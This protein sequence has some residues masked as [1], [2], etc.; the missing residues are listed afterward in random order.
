MSIIT[1]NN[2]RHIRREIEWFTR[3]L[4]T[5]LKLYFGQ[6]CEIPDIFKIPPPKLNDFESIYSNFVNL[7][8]LSFEDRI[9]LILSL[10]PHIKPQLLDIF[11]KKNDFHDKGFT[12]FGGITGHTHNGFIPTAET[13]LF[14]LAGNDL[15]SRFL[16]HNL[17]ESTYLFSQSNILTLHHVNNEESFFS[18]ALALSS[19]YIDLFTTGLVK[20]PGFNTDFPAKLITSEMDWC[21]LVLEQYTFDNLEE[22]RIWMEFGDVMLNE[23]GLKKTV[24]PG[25]RS[26]FY[27]PPGTG[28]TLTAILIGKH[29]GRDVYRIDLSMVVSKY[30]GETE[31]N[32]SKIFSKADNKDWILFFD[33]ADALFGK[34]T[35]VNDAHDRYANQE[36]S[37]LLQ[38]IEDFNGLIILASNMK[39]NIDDAFTRRFQSV[40]YFPMPKPE[41]R[42]KLWQN[43]FSKKSVLEEKIDLQ[44]VAKEYELSGGSIT[45]IV[46]FCS[47]MALKRGDNTIILSDLETGIKREFQKEGKT[48]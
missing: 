35:N 14:I 1:E 39:S 9:V 37:Y 3:V 8:N 7:N 20:K 17:F 19:E 6:E 26:L 5:R 27:G 30:I 43:T 22:I 15:E 31:K 47:L 18:G 12:E 28:K 36:V 45:N 33:E 4:D 44:S 40:I 16:Y 13:A 24:K 25:Y 11:F 10:I 23:W 41:L 38:R 46:R 34:R 42:L 32:L 29:T 48:K 21:D 2:A